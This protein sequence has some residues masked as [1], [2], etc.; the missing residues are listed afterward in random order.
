MADAVHQTLLGWLCGQWEEVATWR[1]K[2]W[3]SPLSLTRCDLRF[4]ISAFSYTKW[5]YVT[6]QN[7]FKKITIKIWERIF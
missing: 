4:S 6:S 3:M 7:F 5:V 1:P 2:V